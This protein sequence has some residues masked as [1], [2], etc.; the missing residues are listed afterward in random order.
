MNFTYLI[1][2]N[3]YLCCW[4]GLY[5]LICSR[6]T[7]FRINRFILLGGYVI[8]LILPLLSLAEDPPFSVSAG[9]AI[10]VSA[11][12]AVL[13][14]QPDIV[15]SASFPL[16]QLLLVVYGMG[17]VVSFVFFLRK[18][19]KIRHLI[20]RLPR[21]SHGGYVHIQTPDQWEVF[22]FMRYLFAPDAITGS[23]LEH[24]KVHIRQKHSLDNLLAEMIRIFCW[25]NPF[26]Y[27]YQKTIKMNHEYLADSETVR[28]VEIREYAQKLVNESFRLSGLSLVHPFLNRSHLQKRLIMLRKVTKSSG[29]RWTYLLLLPSLAVILCSTSAFSLKKRL[30]DRFSALHSASP[31]VTAYFSSAEKDLTL[32][33]VIHT[34]SGTPVVGANVIV[35][36]TGKGIMTDEEGHFILKNV[37]PGSIL[38]ITSVGYNSLTIRVPEERDRINIVLYPK[39]QTLKLLRVTGYTKDTFTLPPPPPSPSPLQASDRS[40]N[41]NAVFQFVEQMPVFPG[42]QDALLRYLVSNIKYPKAAK[43]AG[44]QGTVVVQFVIEKDGAVSH[45]KTVG[46]QKSKGLEEEAIRI[47]KNMPRWHAG[48]QNGKKVRVEYALPIR[49]KLYGPERQENTINSVSKIPH[50]VDSPVS[51][52]GIS[53]KEPLYPSIRKMP[54]FPG[55]QKALMKYLSENTR[56][57]SDAR[58]NG[59]QGTV[60]VQFIVEKNG[61]LSHIKT[62]G[63]KKGGGLEEEA[64]RVVKKMPK[65]EPGRRNGKVARVRYSLPIRFLLQ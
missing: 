14:Q 6:K 37:D 35:G 1:L 12:R 51:Q 20:L 62:V 13:L 50:A 49:F 32:K 9:T 25:F 54:S 65:W 10:P 63:D 40:K 3:L 56:Y 46:K 58:E 22:S 45:V 52:P 29:K 31:A 16:W 44:V 61:F 59:V 21:Q 41:G 24:E 42:G 38:S 23:I 5:Y 11:T 39:P 18:L 60:V 33:G 28:I 8:A 27:L 48:I 17:V 7:T 15:P 55:G 57:P 2:F 64:V 34:P 30:K 47:V 36:Q 53:G 43:K 19:F 26:I 4:L